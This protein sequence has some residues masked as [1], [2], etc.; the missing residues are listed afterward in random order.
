M[1]EPLI[2]GVRVIDKASARAATI[3]E[4]MGLYCSYRVKYEDGST[5]V[6][7]DTN[8][9]RM[10]T[11]EEICKD[12]SVKLGQDWEMSNFSSYIDFLRGKIYITMFPNGDINMHKILFTAEQISAISA[13]CT[14]L[15]ANW[16]AE[17]GKENK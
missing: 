14:E 16:E 7:A 1:S 17:H 8:V 6:V 15:A 4:E 10:R 13:A 11:F 9:T 5:G 3:I 12:L 2:V